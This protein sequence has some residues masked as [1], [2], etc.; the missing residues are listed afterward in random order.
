MVGREICRLD[1][2]S[3]LYLSIQSAHLAE[4]SRMCAFEEYIER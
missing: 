2:W 4:V 3:G 1:L